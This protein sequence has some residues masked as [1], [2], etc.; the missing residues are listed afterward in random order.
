MIFILFFAD[1]VEAWELVKILSQEN[2]ISRVPNDGEDE[3]NALDPTG[4]RMIFD[5]LWAHFWAKNGSKNQTGLSGILTFL[6]QKASPSN[7][8]FNRLVQWIDWDT[9]NFLVYSIEHGKDND[10]KID[11]TEIDKMDKRC[12]KCIH[13]EMADIIIVTLPSIHAKNLTS[14]LLPKF[15]TEDLENIQYENR[16]ACSFVVQMSSKLALNICE[17]FGPEKT[18]INFDLK[19]PSSFSGKFAENDNNINIHLMIWQDRKTKS[20]QELNNHIQE[21]LDARNSDNDKIE[22]SFTF[23]STVDSFDT[24]KTSQ[25]FENYA[26]NFLYNLVSKE[27]KAEQNANPKIFEILKSRSVLWPFSQPSAPM[28]A[29]YAEVKDLEKAYPEGPIYVDDAGLIL[30]GDYFTQSSYIGCFCSAAA[31]TRAVKNII[32]KNYSKN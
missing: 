2:I 24:F 7:L 3:R 28:E 15:V 32:Y 23:H 12:N 26:Q 30:A 21:K 5:N 19:S 9:K 4:E 25:E 22:L 6:L 18:E 27:E 16:A 29:L 17:M 13:I 1:L 10:S 8:E 11:F 31:A 14:H 20:Y